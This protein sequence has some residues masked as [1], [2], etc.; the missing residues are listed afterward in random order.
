VASQSK[1]VPAWYIPNII[2]LS[3]LNYQR[4]NMFSSIGNLQHTNQLPLLLRSQRRVTGTQAV[5]SSGT[6]VISAYNRGLSVQP[7]VLTEGAS[8]W[9]TVPAQVG[10][11]IMHN[12]P[13]ALMLIA[14][15]YNIQTRFVWMVGRAA[16]V[17]V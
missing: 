1:K 10:L 12:A 14:W 15:W 17:F 5:L 7:A 13:H 6:L 16:I 4:T 11:T 8:I 3:A 9:L 2:Y